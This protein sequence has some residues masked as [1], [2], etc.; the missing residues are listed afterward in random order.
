MLRTHE[1]GAETFL[2]AYRWE[3]WGFYLLQGVHLRLTQC[4]QV[5]VLCS[6][7]EPLCP[8]GAIEST[9]QKKFN[10]RQYQSSNTRQF[11]YTGSLL[12]QSDKSWPYAGVKDDIAVYQHNSLEGFWTRSLAQGCK[13][14]WGI[15]W[16]HLFTDA[17]IRCNKSFTSWNCTAGVTG[18]SFD[19][20]CWRWRW[21]RKASQI[22]EYRIV[23]AKNASKSFLYR[24]EAGQAR[25]R[26]DLERHAGSASVA[27]RCPLQ[28]IGCPS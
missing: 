2:L 20:E 26:V 18:V 22:N 24:D 21:P 4:M 7:S 28:P 1:V 16:L 11:K 3:N 12:L 13:E 17:A 10:A 8:S 19:Q 23:K 9:M 25:I 5:E 15:T 27:D 6:L 14:H